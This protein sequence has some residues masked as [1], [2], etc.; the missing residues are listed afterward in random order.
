MPKCIQ[1]TQFMFGDPKCIEHC[2]LIKTPLNPSILFL[3][4]DYCFGIKK[5]KKIKIKQTSFTVV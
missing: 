4:F 1:R 3:V 5:M 2:P